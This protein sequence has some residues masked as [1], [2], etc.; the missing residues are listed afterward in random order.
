MDKRKNKERRLFRFNYWF[1]HKSKGKEETGKVEEFKIGS[2][3]EENGNSLD[4][5]SHSQDKE[6][7]SISF[8]IDKNDDMTNINIKEAP[9]F[10]CQKNSLKYLGNGKALDTSSPRKQK[11]LG[12]KKKFRQ[13][14]TQREIKNQTKKKKI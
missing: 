8:D 5:S 2:K 7:E 9:I 3:R 11:K 13:S 6:D 10:N 1:C 12:F 14:L 4:K